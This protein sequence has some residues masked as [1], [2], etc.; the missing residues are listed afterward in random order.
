[1]TD[2]R[3]P[4]QTAIQPRPRLIDNAFNPPFLRRLDVRLLKTNPLLWSLRLHHAAY[5]GVIGVVFALI[6]SSLVPIGRNP[7]FPIFMPLGKIAVVVV[8]AVL[9]FAWLRGLRRFNAA[10]EFGI[11]HDERG[12]REY[13]GYVVG[14]LLILAALPIFLTNVRVQLKVRTDRVQLAQDLLLLDVYRDRSAR[15]HWEDWSVYGAIREVRVE[16]ANNPLDNLPTYFGWKYLIVNQINAEEAREFIGRNLTPT[17]IATLAAEFETGAGPLHDAIAAN[18][19][20]SSPAFDEAHR[21]ASR[22]VYGQFKYGFDGQQPYFFSTAMI[23]FALAMQLGMAAFVMNYVRRNTVLVAAS[24][25]IGLLVF[26]TVAW[27]SVFPVYEILDR[28]YDLS[29]FYFLCITLIMFGVALFAYRQAKKISAD[30]QFSHHHAVA[31]LLLPFFITIAPLLFVLSLKVIGGL[32]TP[33]YP[34]MHSLHYRY[35]PWLEFVSQFLYLP[36][37]PFFYIKLVPFMKRRLVRL[38]SLPRN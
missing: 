13:L 6:V 17:H 32:H 12:M 30:T 21:H 11:E 24:V 9:I 7:T 35:W 27:L 8:Q 4:S 37:I 3:L 36:L 2:L 1:M 38:N 33:Y 5:L 29:G 16:F 26:H 10:H 31:L 14:F 25:G 34:R 20:V 22:T 23:T 19:V 28:S 18:A 15:M